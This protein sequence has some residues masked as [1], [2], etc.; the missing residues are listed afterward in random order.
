MGVYACLADGVDCYTQS[1]VQLGDYSTVSQRSFLCT[2]SHDISQL[3][4]PLISS[5]IRIGQHAWICAEVFVGPGVEI[6]EGAVVA[7]RGVVTRNVAAWKI[8]GGS[9]AREIGHRVLKSKDNA[10]ER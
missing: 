6:E 1:L 9:P 4:R 7:A 5:P 2:A 8:V 3:S 10:D